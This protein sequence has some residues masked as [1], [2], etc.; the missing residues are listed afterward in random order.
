MILNKK[1]LLNFE[2][3]GLPGFSDFFDPFTQTTLQSKIGI[4]YKKS[5]TFD[6][7]CYNPLSSKLLPGRYDLLDKNTQKLACFQQN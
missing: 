3:K 4:F 1:P 6:E 5:V 7:A 2:F